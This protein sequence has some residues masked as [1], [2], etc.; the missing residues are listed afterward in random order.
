MKMMNR[1]AV[2]MVQSK[3]TTKPLF[4]FDKLSARPLYSLLSQSDI[5]ALRKIATSIRY[6]GN[7]EKRFKKIDEIMHRRGFVKMSAGTNRICYGFIEDPTICVKVAA[8][9]TAIK[10][11]P[12]EFMNQE[13]LKPFCTKVFEVSPC[14]TVGLFERVIP[15]QSREEFMSVAE[16]VFALIDL[17][18][19]KYILSDF[20][21]KYFM[22]YGIR[23]GFGPV[24][25]DFP[26]LYEADINKLV[27]HK[28]IHLANGTTKPCGGLIDY[29]DGYNYLI[30]KKCAANY[31]AIE[32]AKYINEISIKKGNVKMSELKI[33]LRKGDK[34]TKLFNDSVNDEATHVAKASTIKYGEV[35]ILKAKKVA[36][37][38]VVEE[39][40]VDAELVDE[41]DNSSVVNITVKDITDKKRNEEV[42]KPVETKTV[43][44]NTAKINMQNMLKAAKEKDTTKTG[45][46]IIVSAKRIPA[47]TPTVDEI[48]NDIDN[49][50]KEKE[51]NNNDH[52][53]TRPNI[54]KTLSSQDIINAINVANFVSEPEEVEEVT[55]EESWT[56][57]SVDLENQVITY[58]SSLGNRLTLPMPEIE[59]NNSENEAEIIQLN[60]DLEAAK[61][62]IVKSNEDAEEKINN[63]TAINTKLEEALENAVAIEQEKNNKIAELEERIRNYESAV[64]EDLEESNDEDDS[65]KFLTHCVGT[66]TTIKNLSNH[67]TN[68]SIDIEGTNPDDHIIALM[69]GPDYV[70]DRWGNPL[71]ISS[72]MI[73]DTNV[74]IADKIISFA[75]DKPSNRK[76]K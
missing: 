13:N 15:I 61:A 29:D 21:S 32:L 66:M 56:V 18:T 55:E 75:T 24:L 37:P 69:Q 2:E 23:D 44:I 34:V 7:P 62:E 50:L 59:N 63:I 9:R 22:N 6:S 39:K 30:C 10:D 53:V 1:S 47:E 54:D 68:K 38:V 3:V 31:R 20:G 17:L 74:S 65:T 64:E 57:S 25:L 27:C 11:N 43:D 28:P 8:D 46:T 33:V 36:A 40:K 60:N 45:D 26:Y 5:D 41:K 49:Y 42:H 19:C 72:F 76:E 48:I 52:L 73:K 67:F 71:V 35:A 70:T 58:E 4:E 14:G 51:N 12:R 16:D